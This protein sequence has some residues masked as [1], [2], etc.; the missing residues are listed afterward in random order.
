[1]IEYIN[2]MLINKILPPPCGGVLQ[3]SRVDYVDTLKGLAILWIIW[4]HTDCYEFLP[5]SNPVFFF[6]SGIFFKEK[7]FRE[8]ARIRLNRLIVPFLFFYLLSYPFRMVVYYW[9]NMT[10]SGFNFGCIADVFRVEAIS[11]YLFINVPLWFLLCLCVIHF[12]FYG[13]ARWP[14][15]LLIVVAA[16]IITFKVDILSVPSPF[17]INNACYWISYFILGFTIGRWFVDNVKTRMQRV[18]AL[19]CCIVILCAI[20]AISNTAWDSRDVNSVIYHVEVL[21]VILILLAS[22]SI[23]DGCRWLGVLRFYGKN[24]LSVLGFHLIILIPLTR[25][26]HKFYPGYYP[27]G[28]LAVS[29]ITAVMLYPLIKLMN[30]RYPYFVGKADLSRPRSRV[31]AAGGA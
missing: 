5:N 10:L 26:L 18:V 8:F 11:D 21:L 25:V 4:C 9:D 15:P 28:G 23:F 30:R 20:C 29:I 14:K 7:P 2:N 17:M 22:F 16:I 27:L 6:A 19:V 3:Q 24:S 31:G 13:M 12:L 1:M